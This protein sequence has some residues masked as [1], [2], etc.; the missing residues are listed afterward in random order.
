MCNWQQKVFFALAVLF[1]LLKKTVKSGPVIQMDETTVQVINEP[2]RTYA[3][4]S[5]MWLARGG[6]PDKK[7]IWYEYHP[8]REACNAKGFLAGYSGYLQT[9][10]FRG[11]DTAVE[12]MAGITHVGCFAHAR[13]KFFEASKA[14]KHR[15]KSPPLSA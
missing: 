1:M 12:G 6:P 10:G 13:R 3:Q 5:Y 4:K 7:V 9:D 2:D 15:A 11:Y 14:G 8:T